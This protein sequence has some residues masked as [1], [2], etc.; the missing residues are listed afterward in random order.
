[1]FQRKPEEQRR[2]RSDKRR[3][4]KGALL[5]MGTMYVLLTARTPE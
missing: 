2:E 3:N 5:Y 1:M 4:P